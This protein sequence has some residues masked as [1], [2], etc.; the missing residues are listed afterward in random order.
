M[1]EPIVMKSRSDIADPSLDTERMLSEL[2]NRIESRTDSADPI[3]TP[4]RRLMELPKCR[5]PRA[6]TE[7]PILADARRDTLEPMRR[8]STMDMQPLSFTEDRK[9]NEEPT[10]RKSMMLQLWTEP[11]RVSCK[12][13]MPLPTR[14]YWR[15][16]RAE[17]KLRKSSTETCEPQRMKLR[18]DIELPT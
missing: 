4:L 8:K 9:L 2:P 18:S 12:T 3:L 11:S 5:N 15:S 14:A 7:E 1:L 6:E 13:L 17:P 10:L 16:D